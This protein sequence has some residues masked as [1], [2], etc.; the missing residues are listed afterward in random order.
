MLEDFVYFNNT[1]FSSLSLCVTL[2]FRFKISEKSIQQNA[3]EITTNFS[4]LTSPPSF[5]L[6]C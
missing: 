1:P 4:F 6:N 5:T 2:G 3:N